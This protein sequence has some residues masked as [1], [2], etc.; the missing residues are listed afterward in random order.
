ME[1]WY[2]LK[3]MGG[4]WGLGGA[5]SAAL[6]AG[7]R[8][9]GEF[10]GGNAGGRAGAAPFG[11]AG[12]VATGVWWRGGG[13]EERVEL[14]KRAADAVGGEVALRQGA[15]PGQPVVGDDRACQ[16]QLRVGEHD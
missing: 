4:E 9:R 14:R 5:A 11:A 13:A 2:G 12:G 15:L 1:D 3:R 10:D 6:A 7:R 8:F 16:P